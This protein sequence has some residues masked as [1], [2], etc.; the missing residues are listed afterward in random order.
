MEGVFLDSL[1]F[2]DACAAVIGKERER[3]GIGTLSE[4]TLHA[5]LKRYLEPHTENHE[6]KI[7]SYVADIV[8]ENGIIEIQ[9]GSFTPLRPKLECLLD[10]ADVTVVYP[11]AAVKRIAWADPE[12]GEIT[13]SRISPKKMKPC[14]AFFE[15]IRIKYTLDNPHMKLKLMM[16]ELTELRFAGK[17]P[18]NRARG[19][20]RID[21]IPSKLIDEIDLSSPQDYD[22]FI[23]KGLPGVFGIKDFAAHAGVSYDAA[24]RALNVLCYLERVAPCGKLGRIKQF[25]KTTH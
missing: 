25:T 16:L 18:R 1:R 10:Y 21:R 15:L 22:Y 2:A 3:C 13:A 11:M 4:K 8:G 17:D 19:S 9:T 23:P 5:V 20:Q 24:Q 7:G 6:V 12:T 14:D